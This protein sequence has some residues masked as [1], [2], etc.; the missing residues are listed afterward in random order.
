MV[1]IPNLFEF[2]IMLS[3]FKLLLSLLWHFM[4]IF[5]HWIIVTAYWGSLKHFVTLFFES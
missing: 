5:I 4:N 2:T 3:T 1:F